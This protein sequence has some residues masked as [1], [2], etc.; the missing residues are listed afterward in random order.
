MP[1]KDISHSKLLSS[2]FH[3]KPVVEKEWAQV[4]FRFIYG[5]RHTPGIR[6]PKHNRQNLTF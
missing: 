6:K 5:K 1:G 3:L 2:T 4:A